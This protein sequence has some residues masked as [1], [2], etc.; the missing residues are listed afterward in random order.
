LLA[1]QAAQADPTPPPVIYRALSTEACTTLRKLIVP[2]GYI[3]KRNNAAFRAMSASLDTFLGLM[4]PK[5]PVESNE[6][7]L[8]G[9]REIVSIAR[10]DSIAQDIYN[11]LALADRYMQQSW[12]E[13]PQGG[14]LRVDALR[15]QAQAMID[16]QRALADRYEQFASTYLHYRDMPDLGGPA[17][18]QTLR[19]VILAEASALSGN[20]HYAAQ[21]GFVDTGDLARFAQAPK[22]ARTLAD[23]EA[24][25]G[26]QEVSTYKQCTGMTVP[27]TVPTAFASP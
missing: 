23:R 19:T 24:T 2:V 21:A 1:N 22:I 18:P 17:D 13:Y 14:D 7:L 20:E 5:S 16:S 26:T 4:F 25:F 9:P 12:S 27:L 11:N 15:Q 10:I 6:E 3:A 8:Y